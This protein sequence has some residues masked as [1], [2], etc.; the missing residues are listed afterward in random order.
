MLLFNINALN[1]NT[2][3]VKFIKKLLDASQIEFRDG[4]LSGYDAALSG[5][6]DLIFVV[7]TI[8]RMTK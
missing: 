2:Y 7:E 1:S 6:F 8:L 3:N 5:W 4:I